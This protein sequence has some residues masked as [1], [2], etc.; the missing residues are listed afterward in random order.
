[1]KIALYMAGVLA[2]FATVGSGAR[3]DAAEPP[4]PLQP[5][6]GYPVRHDTSPPLRSIRPIA[7]MAP[8]TIRE[9]PLFP[10][11]RPQ[12]TGPT[13][14][15]A[16]GQAPDPV[17]QHWAGALAMPSPT[18]NFEGISNVDGVLPPDTNGDVGP[19]HYVQMVNL[20]FAI[21]SK[22]G[23]VL[24]GPANTNTLWSGFGG[25]CE[26]TNDG[27]P[28][29]LYDHLADRWVMSQFANAFAGP[30]FH[31]CIAISQNGDPTGAWHRYDFLYSTTKFNDYPKFGVWPDAYYM[32]ANQFDGGG[33]AGAGVVAF[34]RAKMLAGL[35]AQKV[36]F[37]LFS[38]NPN[39]GGML[40]ADLDGPPPPVGSPNYFMEVDDTIFGFPTDSVRLW[41]FHVDW[42]NPAA[43]S[44]FGLSGAP[45]AVLNTAPFDSNLCNFSRKCIPQRNTTRRLDAL[46]DRLMYRLQYRNFGTHESLVVNHTVDADGADHAGIRWYE[47]RDP[48][49]APFIHQQGTYAPD[50]NH[51]WMGSVAMDGDGNMA[52]GFSISSA[53]LFPSIRYVGRL[54]GDPLGTMP[55]GEATLIAGRGSQTHPSSRWGDYSMLAVDPVDDC[56]FWYTQEYYSTT[57]L[58]G[59][60]T[61]I[62]AFKFPTCG[63][64]PGADLSVTKTDAPDPVAVGGT[65]TYTV[66]VTNNGPDAATGVVMTDTLP[67]SV[68]FVSAGPSCTH[69]SGTVTCGLG[70]LANGGAT[71]VTIMVTPTAAGT[72]T[73]TA[74]VTGNETDPNSA[75]NTATAL[76]T[77][78]T[79]GGSCLGTGLNTLR[80]SVRTGGR[81]GTAIPNV[82][83]TLT[84]PN[85]CTDTTTTGATGLYTFNQLA[86]GTYTVTPS[87][88]GCTFTP[89]SRTLTLSGRGGT[90]G[91]TGTCQSGGGGDR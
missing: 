47:V 89:S 87:K 63:G 24:F 68:T 85:G 41:E 3:V 29:V 73:N 9:I 22:S 10:R 58:A 71:T 91:F 80:G 13:A 18:Q 66:A 81:S 23:T 52:L 74:S 20:S 79:G 45:N 76:T 21:F 4:G 5:V 28:I 40:P 43:L 51:R 27:D 39:F 53:T 70:S 14:A 2:L 38:V 44:T 11:P 46:S 12:P 35:P 56:T 78:N 16:E 62:G 83:M 6:V 69:L 30:P 26:T 90:A 48:G 7:P 17:V 50:A 82:T 57:S 59:W 33:W 77:V 31:Q 75:N 65:L 55:Q 54:A 34:E 36:S 37:D 1:M 64:A 84:G 67:P 60:L 88:A 86:N 49:G 8:A 19:N 15:L 32:T 25:P 72:L 61:R 42:T